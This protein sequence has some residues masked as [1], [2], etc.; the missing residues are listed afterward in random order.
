M[1]KK[2][3]NTNY[4]FK[5]VYTLIKRDLSS[6]ILSII[7]LGFVF[8]I[9][10]L[11]I[12]LGVSSQFMISEISSQAEIS[13][14]YSENYDPTYI[15]EE[16][17]LI[18]G[19]NK[20]NLID[21][22]EANERMKDILGSDRKILELFDHNPFSSY[23]EVFIE[24]DNLDDIVSVSKNIEG[25]ELVRD[26]REV[27]SQ[28]KNILNIITILGVFVFVAISVA[29]VVITAHIIRQGV[30]MNKDQISTLKLLGAPSYFIYVPFVLNGILMTVLSA[31]SS[32]ILVYLSNNFVYSK[33]E[34]VLPFIILPNF[35]D[36]M[37]ILVVFN[38]ISGII[39]GFLGSVLGIK[40][41]NLNKGA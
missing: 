17:E 20:V 28:L 21:S 36:L 29:T 8:F 37:I 12:S 32:I 22:N 25:V 13:I 35:V 16:L 41:T 4:Y 38:L 18:E 40:T 30:Y 31:L 23:I 2:I 3:N 24:L 14:Y 7:S 6:N 34:G 1:G 33:I 9:I 10:S 15:R 19:I 5:E 26:N 27:L 39:L 11:V